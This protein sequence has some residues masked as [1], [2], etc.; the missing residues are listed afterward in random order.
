[1]RFDAIRAR[2]QTPQCELALFAGQAFRGGVREVYGQLVFRVRSDL[3][4]GILSRFRF[5]F[6]VAPRCDQRLVQRRGAALYA[7][8]FGMA[9]DN[10]LSHYRTERDERQRNASYIRAS[11]IYAARFSGRRFSAWQRSLG[12]QF[13]L[14]VGNTVEL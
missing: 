14:A 12:R 5:W 6:G 2:T 11:H 3:L 7:I 8:Q 4:L 13:I 1:M 10:N 9:F